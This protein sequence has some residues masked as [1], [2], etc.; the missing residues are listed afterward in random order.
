MS[1]ISEDAIA[2]RPAQ[3]LHFD[4]PEPDVAEP[5][6]DIADEVTSELGGAPQPV[7]AQAQPPA[8]PASAD[9]AFAPAPGS[10]LRERYVLEA[11]IGGG[12]TAMVFRALDRR[13][14]GATAGGARVAI[15][16][17]R[18]ER[19]DDARSIAR[20]QR[21]FRQ[22]QAA[23]HPGVVRVFDLDFDR[24]YWFIVMELL[25]G[26]SLAAGLRRCAPSGLPRRQALALSYGIAD[27]LAH[28]HARGVI[29]LS[30]G[31]DVLFELH[32]LSSL[33]D[34]S[35][36]HF[37]TFEAADPDRRWLNDVIAVGEGAIDVE[38]G[39]LSM[40][41]YECVVELPLPDFIS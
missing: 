15:K 2:T 40:R 33:A 1:A 36:V 38:R 35:G 34:G 18:P 30:D 7:R 37:M 9:P 3:P 22:T 16:L 39:Q 6:E 4:A 32:G 25:D 11:Q 8:P 17:L 41:Y 27:A 20:L 13:R 29:H 24:G 12:G 14:D 28:A 26:E 5:T 31:G 21:E 19:R 23:A 10:V